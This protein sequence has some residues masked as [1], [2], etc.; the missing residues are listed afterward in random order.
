MKRIH[1]LILDSDPRHSQALFHVL[2]QESDFSILTSHSLDMFI[3]IA[4][5][6]T[7]NVLIID[8]N[9]LFPQISQLKTI[10]YRHPNITKPHWLITASPKQIENQKGTM[11]EY[12]SSLFKRPVIARALIHSIRQFS[13]VGP[14]IPDR[15]RD[16]SREHD[17]DLLATRNAIDSKDL[18]NEANQL[19]EQRQKLNQVQEKLRADLQRLAGEKEKLDA[20]KRELV[21]QQE[22]FTRE[23][24]Q[25]FTA[26]IKLREERENLEKEKKLLEQE[27]KYLKNLRKQ[28]HIEK[29]LAQSGRPSNYDPNSEH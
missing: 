1:I 27:K 3:E 28:V 23:E 16:I 17:L 9:V 4:S 8:W 15:G 10:I 6:R 11:L 14:S 13:Q 7:L 25:L 26:Q 19:F 12:S 22:R 2:N 29:N 20:E 18:Q 21:S 24:N 5:A